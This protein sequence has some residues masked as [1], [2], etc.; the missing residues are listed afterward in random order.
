MRQDTSEI[1][2]GAQR[3]RQPSLTQDG[4]V[5][6]CD[7]GPMDL[8]TGDLNPAPRPRNG[9]MVRFAT[10]QL[11]APNPRCTV[12]GQERGSPSARD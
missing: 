12:V 6:R 7:V 4:N 8:P 1:Q 5:I 10:D 11:D 9:E 2:N 3:S